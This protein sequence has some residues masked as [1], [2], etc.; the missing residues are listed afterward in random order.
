MKSE[1]T[2]FNRV[3]RS[4]V[5]DRALLMTFLNSND[6]T[7]I[8]TATAVD[9]TKGENVPM[10]RHTSDGDSRFERD[11][12]GRAGDKAKKASDTAR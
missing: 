5:S 6:R 9:A 7:G 10:P 8:D 3:M 12:H 4:S 2:R 11:S 1:L